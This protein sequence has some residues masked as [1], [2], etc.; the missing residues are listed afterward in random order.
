MVLAYHLILSVY[1]FWLPN[2][3][4]GSWSDFVWAY[5]LTRF[6]PATKVET[7]ASVA[8]VEHD[9]ALRAAAKRALRY[10][11]VRFDGVQGREVA[12]GIARVVERDRIVVWACAVMPDHV[13]LVVARHPTLLCEEIASRFKQSASRALT[14]AGVHPMAR[15]ADHRGR[16]PSP[17]GEGEWKV[18][19]DSPN[20]VTRATAYVR[21]NPVRDGMKPQA[22][23]QFV[24]PFQS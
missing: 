1:G 20:D 18:Y 11:P 6:G 24:S 19:L 4:R 22:W 7:H 5:E 8:H 21:N 10:L 14:L 9:R 3:P 16:V 23:S 13:H 2:D 17:W 12:R 15:Y